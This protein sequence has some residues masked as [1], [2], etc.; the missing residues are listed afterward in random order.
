MAQKDIFNLVRM[1]QQLPEEKQHALV[2]QFMNIMSLNEATY[3]NNCSNM[4]KDFTFCNEKPDCP[5]CR[6]Q[7]KLGFIIKR[8]FKKGVQRYF[9]KACKHVFMPTTNTAFEKT[10]KSSDTWRRFIELTISGA[11]LQKCSQECKIAYQTAFTWR[12]KVLNAFRV[13]QNTTILLGKIELDEMLIPISYK[14][15]HIKGSFNEQRKRTYKYDNGLPRKSFQRGSDNKSKSS[16]SKACVLCMVKNGN[17]AFYASVPGIGFMN[18]AMLD[19]TVGKHVKKEDT[20]VLVDQ[21]KV[22]ANYLANN[23]YNHM[24]LAAN[25][26]ENYNDHKPE[27]RDDNHLQHVNAMHMHLRRFLRKYCGVSTKYLENYISLYV[28][29]KNITAHKQKKHTQK[30]S[31]SRMATS[32]CYI[33]RKK[34]ESFPAVPAC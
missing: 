26:S 13:H 10:R 2:Q 1:M 11:S 27:I 31:V 23:N 3:Q 9:C 12:H 8:G 17:E 29:L 33:T 21:Y 5:H 15:N 6:A 19:K 28:W 4:V 16:K 25:T 18:N 30:M 24:I 14:G 7:A 22:T 32:D 20:M 34:L